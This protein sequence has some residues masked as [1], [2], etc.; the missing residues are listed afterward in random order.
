MPLGIMPDAKIADHHVEMPAGGTLSVYTDGCFE[1]RRDSGSF[2]GSDRFTNTLTEHIKRGTPNLV[3]KILDDI[4]A[5]VG[6]AG[7]PDDC[8]LVAIRHQG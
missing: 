8:T 1:W 4:T 2:L 7:L 5:L 3:E 6:P